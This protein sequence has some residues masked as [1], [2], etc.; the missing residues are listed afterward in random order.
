MGYSHGVTKSQTWLGMCSHMHTHNPSL[1]L[2]SFGGKSQTEYNLFVPVWMAYDDYMHHPSSQSQVVGSALSIK[3]GLLIWAPVP[4]N[5][6]CTRDD[7]ETNVRCLSGSLQGTQGHQST[8]CSWWRWGRG[9]SRCSPGGRG[10]KWSPGRGPGSRQGSSE[11]LVV[12][13][14]I[15][16]SEPFFKLVVTTLCPWGPRVCTGTS[17]TSYDYRA[18]HR[19]LHHTHTVPPATFILPSST[20]KEP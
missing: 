8:G 14:H 3:N 16:N 18:R 19:G 10:S 15:Q 1:L 4:G 9:W 2:L 6:G 20:R 17:H 5:A 12:G 13:Q 7:L 11:N